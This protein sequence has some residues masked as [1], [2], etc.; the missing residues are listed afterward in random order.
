MLGFVG[1]V[2]LDYVGIVG[3]QIVTILL[4]AI[5]IVLITDGIILISDAW[6]K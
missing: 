4:K 3:Y 6:K 1:T 5:G 2:F